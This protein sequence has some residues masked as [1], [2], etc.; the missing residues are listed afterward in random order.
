M[1]KVDQDRATCYH[2]AAHAV[3]AIR[4]CGGCVRYVD[5]DEAYC[6]AG[7]SNFG[8]WA[9]YWRKALQT[10]AGKFAEMLDAWKEVR[11]KA[12]EELLEIAEMV[13]MGEVES[14]DD[15]DLVKLIY[16][17]SA[18]SGYEPEEEYWGVVK[19]TEEEVRR[20][21]PE[22]TAVAEALQEARRLSGEE[23]EQIV[24]SV[25]EGKGEGGTELL[26]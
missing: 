20:L 18:D 5:A 4:V 13:D 10:R 23:V 24:A 2:E 3:F 22:I 7:L 6:L 21:W 1:H 11:P 26:L 9:E 19:E 16:E 17:M 14:C 8:G 15:S 25:E 12:W